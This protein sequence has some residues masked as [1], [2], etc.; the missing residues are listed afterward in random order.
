M[1]NILLTAQLTLREALSRKIFIAF[2][3]I[4]TFI[5]LIFALLFIFLNPE[6]FTGMVKSPGETIDF[7]KE[8]A[9][10]LKLLVVAPLFG[11]GIFLS[12]FSASSFIPNMLEK[13]NIDLLLSKPLSRHQLI[14]GKFLGGLAVVALNIAYAVIGFWI[15]VG[16]KFG[17]WDADFL[18]TIFSI[19]FAFASLYSLIILIGIITRSSI[20]AMMLSYIIFF[21][22]SPV[23]NMRDSINAV[24]DSS[25]L[26]GILDILY[27]ILPKITELGNLTTE[28]CIGEGINQWQPILT[29]FLFMILTLYGGIFI[30]SKKDY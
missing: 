3:G 20:L 12:I 22:L 23:L 30:F 29:S 9:Y 21:I 16:L 11:L 2:G 18:L 17:V 25:F 28:L 5:L 14:I 7:T 1:K 10:G 4:S 15:L 27:Y 19:T 26:K 6:E 8:I 24:V 13:G